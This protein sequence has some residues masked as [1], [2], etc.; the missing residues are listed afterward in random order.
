MKFRIGMIAAALALAILA[1]CALEG[2]AGAAGSNG[3]NGTNGTNGTNGANGAGQVIALAR[4]GR[5]PSQGFNVGASEIVEYD[6][7]NN[8]IFSVNAQSGLVDVFAAT[9]FTALAAP[10]QSLDLRQMLVD[11]GK[12]ALVGDV[13][14]ANSLAVSGNLVAV[15]VEANPK[16][17]TGWVVFLNAA[18]LAYVN[19][20]SVG[21]LPDM[22]TFTPDGTRVLVA[23]EGEPNVGYSIDPEGSVSV[24]NA[25]TFAVTT[26]GFNDF[27]VGNSRNAEL[28][29]VFSPTAPTLLNSR[30][31]L[32]GIGATVAQDLEPEYISVR[33]DGQRAYVSLQEANAIAVL[34][35]TNNTVERIVGLGFKDHSIPGNELDASNQDGVAIRTWPVYGIYMPDTLASFSYNGRNYV[36]TANEGDS[37]E[38]WVAGLTDSASCTGNGYYF[39]SSACRDELELRNLANSDLTLGTTLTGLNTDTTLGRLRFSYRATRFMNNSTTINRIYTYGTRSFSIWDMDSGEQVYDSGNAFE[40]ITAQRYGTLFNQDH[41]G[42]ATGDRRSNTKGPEPEALAVGR[43]SGHTYAFV[44]LERMGG[45]MVHDISNPFAPQFVQY[46]NDRN[47]GITANAAAV[48]AGGDL[49]PENI[50]F[51]PASGNPRSKPLLIVGNEVS[52]TTSVYEITV[53]ALQE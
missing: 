47:V 52:G 12:A 48:T 9:D 11:N 39:F 30:M 8:R 4:I 26:I 34:D 24:I 35:L 17:N 10:A 15:A 45:I 49:G 23:N 16:T 53:T 37:R 22:V 28:P 2:D 19:A 18:T 21:A 7:A 41:N 44:G 32:G 50:R 36:A 31:V 6:A 29:V 40:R 14:A 1:G 20:A 25:T 5:T 42:A 43:I 27:N 13:G 46:I 3:A 51:V 33:A 38:D